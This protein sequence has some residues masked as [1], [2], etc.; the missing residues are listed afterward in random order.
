MGWIPR[1]GLDALS[2]STPLFVPVF[3]LDRSNSGLIFLRWMG[4]PIPH[5]GDVP[6]FWSLW[7]LSPLLGTSEAEEKN[8]CSSLNVRLS[9][10]S[11]QRVRT[12]TSRRCCLLVFCFLFFVFCFF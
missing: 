7:I 6:N 8:T 4:G 3:P 2:V 1:W 10:L 5:S 9:S 12:K 11:D